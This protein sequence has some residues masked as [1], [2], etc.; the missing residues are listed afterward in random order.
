MRPR[1]SKSAVRGVLRVEDYLLMHIPLQL[2]PS[3]VGSQSSEGSSTHIIP[4]CHTIPEGPP[5]GCFTLLMG[6][7]ATQM[8]GQLMPSLVGS[9]LS[10]GSS[11][12]FIPP[13][14]W[15]AEGPAQ[16]CLGVLCAVDSA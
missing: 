10:A 7:P 3:L 4:P 11:M 1:A 2:T 8:P 6:A 15:I 13:G 16:G 9:H 14:H 12:H 5:Q